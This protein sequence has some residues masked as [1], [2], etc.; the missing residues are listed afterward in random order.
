MYDVFLFITV[1]ILITQ[2]LKGI[3]GTRKQLLLIRMHSRPMRRRLT[4]HLSVVGGGR[5]ILVQERGLSAPLSRTPLL[6]TDMCHT[7]QSVHQIHYWSKVWNQVFYVF[8]EV[9]SAQQGCI[10]LIKHTIENCE[11]LLLLYKKQFFI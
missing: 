3:S 9:S 6:H 5:G 11:I 8:K 4:A 10:Y 7:S 2:E 1:Q